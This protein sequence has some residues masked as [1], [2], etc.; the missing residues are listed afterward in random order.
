MQIT[1]IV[2]SVP[3]VAADSPCADTRYGTP[4]SRTN[5]I[6]ENCVPM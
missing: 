6:I 4:Q 5:T 3:A 2:I 1:K